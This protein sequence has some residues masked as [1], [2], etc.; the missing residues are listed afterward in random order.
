MR[1]SLHDLADS[2]IEKDAILQ[3][4]LSNARNWAIQA[5]IKARCM[6]GDI[7]HPRITFF[8]N[9][10]ELL[11][12]L[13]MYDEANIVEE[14]FHAEIERIEGVDNEALFRMFRP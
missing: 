5:E 14:Q 2:L 8:W 10:L 4:C 1:N 12:G 9:V 6:A 7:K 11:R 13:G 3:L